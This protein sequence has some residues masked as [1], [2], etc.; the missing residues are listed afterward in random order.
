MF[1]DIPTEML[2]RMHELEHR[3]EIDRTDGTSR[4]HR[5]RQIP[6]ETGRF[7]ALWG[8]HRSRS[9]PFLECVSDWNASL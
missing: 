6:P 3:D 4:L 5:L 9:D 7:L 2:E 8:T 1:H